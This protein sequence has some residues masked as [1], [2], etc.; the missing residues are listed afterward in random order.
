MK[1]SMKSRYGLRA[2]ID[3]SVNSK[4]EQVALGSIAERNNISPQYL[5]QV[6]ASLRK[7]GIV[8]SIK[9]SQGGYF[10]NKPAE[11]ITISEVIE[12]LEGDYRIEAEDVP[13]DCDYKAAPEAI[14]KLV[15][16]KVNYELEKILTGI[17]L[18]DLEK[19]YQTYV[20]YGQDMYYI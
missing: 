20:D 7:A 12:A 2:L 17:T 6:F 9:G 19:E 16:D 10:L 3:L 15:I 5:E 14:Q 18:Y 4:N 8:K 11:Q 13:E 1:L